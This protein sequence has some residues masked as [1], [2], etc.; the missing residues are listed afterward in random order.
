MTK[1]SF[2]NFLIFQL[3]AN[4]RSFQQLKIFYFPLERMQLWKAF[5][6]KLSRKTQLYNDFFLIREI[7]KQETQLDKDKN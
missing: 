6:E 3:V 4:K 1:V 2:F 7:A 5:I